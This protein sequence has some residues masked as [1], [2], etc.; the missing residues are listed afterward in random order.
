MVIDR[1]FFVINGYYYYFINNIFVTGFQ[2]INGFVYYF[3][4]DGVMLANSYIDIFD[5]TGDGVLDYLLFN[6]EGHLVMSGGS[7]VIYIN[8]HPYLITG[9]N[10]LSTATLKLNII[11]SDDD[12][13]DR[14]NTLLNNVT[15]EALCSNETHNT[16]TNSEGVATFTSLPY[17]HGTLTLSLNG[18]VTREIPIYLGA[19]STEMTYALDRDVSLTLNGR[20]LVADSDQDYTNNQALADA[21]L[22]LIRVGNYIQDI[23]PITV[24]SNSNGNYTFSGLKA[25]VYQITVH[26]DGY[27]DV[28]DVVYLN[29]EVIT[30]QNIMIEAIKDDNTE[31]GSISGQVRDATKQTVTPISGIT[32]RFRSGIN[33]TYGEV[34]YEVTTDSNG[35]YSLLIAPGN[36]TIEAVDQRGLTTRYST[37]LLIVKVLSNMTLTGQNIA[38]SPAVNGARIVL[39]WGSTPSDLD[40][41]TIFSTGTHIYYSNKS[42]TG[43]GNLDV[44]DT[45]SYGPETTTITNMNYS[46]MFY[47]YNYSGGSSYAL[48]NS[49]A[50]VKVYIGDGEDDI[51]YT[52]NVPYA[53][54]RYWNIFTYRASTGKISFS[55]TVSSSS[56]SAPSY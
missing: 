28:F 17:G 27:K 40:S 55:N 44:D 35:N 42:P 36:Y 5:I 48:S 19:S 23:D 13:N 45:S 46:F 39:T 26:K 9:E 21:S 49:G 6:N 22:T 29:S 1:E 3:G 32:L 14:N 4:S 15:C 7:I 53:S 33:I 31:Y 18:Y 30:T 51:Q 10:V 37:T 12:L 25:G 11:E 47:V 56:P 16:F 24:Y 43:Y 41:H 52:F 20:V 50:V 8:E 34:L 2:V 54:G 38:M